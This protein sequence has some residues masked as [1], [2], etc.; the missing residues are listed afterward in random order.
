MKD[1]E[2]F[3]VLTVIME[4]LTGEK[5]KC[6]FFPLKHW[7]AKLAAK[8]KWAYVVCGFFFLLAV[9]FPYNKSITLRKDIWI[10]LQQQSDPRKDIWISCN[11][12]V[13]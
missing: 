2:N 4:M 12:S 6:L 8:K 5:L 10:H 11:N 3:K 7:N 9:G 1:S 13:I